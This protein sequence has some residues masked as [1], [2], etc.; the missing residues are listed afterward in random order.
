MDEINIGPKRDFR[1]PSR[2]WLVNAAAVALIAATATL[3]MTVGGARRPPRSHGPPSAAAART[4][5]PT[6]A[7]GTMLLTCDTGNWG[8]LGARWRAGSLKAGPLWLV[9]GRQYAYLPRRSFPG[10][11]PGSRPRRHILAVMIVEVPD[12]TTVV[13]KAADTARP[14]F[15]F[16]VGFNGSAGNPLPK[17]ETGF[18]FSACPKGNR[19]PNGSFTDFYLGFIIGAGRAAPVDI[20]K[21]ASSHPI[22]LIFT[23]PRQ[24]SGRA[25]VR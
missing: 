4:R 10:T 15:H 7:P 22:R 17:G 2:R 1:L 11:G 19:G 14:Y 6:A 13:M 3:V 12:G 8:G 9:N 20:Q 24:V 16:V 18:T 25:G 23:S 21:A 5:S